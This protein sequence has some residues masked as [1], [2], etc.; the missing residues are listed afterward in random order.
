MDYEKILKEAHAAAHDATVGGHDRGACGFA[1]VVIDGNHPLARH[2]REQLKKLPA[3]ATYEQRRIYGAKGYPKGWQFWKPGGFPG[4][5][6]DTHEQGAVA[7][8]DTLGKYNIRA[9]AASRLD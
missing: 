7:F 1:W 5:A 2:C 4:Q 6:V 9:D 3:G 8:R